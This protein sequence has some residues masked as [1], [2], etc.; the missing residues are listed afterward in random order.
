MTFPTVV[1]LPQRLEPLSR[2]TFVELAPRVRAAT[3]AV[4]AVRRI[5]D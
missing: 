3:V 1:E 5:L 2:D 4:P